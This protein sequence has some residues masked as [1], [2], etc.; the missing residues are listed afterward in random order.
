[1]SSIFGKIKHAAHH[2]AHEVEHAAEH[3]ADEASDLAHEAGDAIEKLGGTAT[4]NLV[5]QVEHALNSV[6]DEIE[7][8]IKHL[9]KEAT[10]EL[11][12]IGNEVKHEG[13]MWAHQIR[14]DV[15]KAEKGLKTAGEK[16][17]AELKKDAIIALHEAEKLA[18][19]AA[20]AA[21]A[22]LS[23]KMLHLVVEGLKIVV[24]KQQQIQ[25]GPIVV[26]I[27]EI[28]KR[29]DT[30]EKWAKNPPRGKD[31]MRQIIK[32]VAPT[33]VDINLDIAFAFLF[34]ESDS[35]SFGLVASFE[36]DEFLDKMDELLAHYGIH[37]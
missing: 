36:T 27:D 28:H 4:M 15:L 8:D 32:E 19:D 21:L 29:I 11:E 25:L 31:D 1:M 33:S 9:A 12:G 34:V 35:L 5:H 3:A 23:G 14:S 7:S 16:V 24:P 2:A 17:G 10:H 30:L 22:E 37:I 18:E 13:E 26:H 6:K 20:K